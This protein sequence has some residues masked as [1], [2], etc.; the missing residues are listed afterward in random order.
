MGIG[1]GTCQGGGVDNAPRGKGRLMV[2]I[3]P[4]PFPQLP[5]PWGFCA[6]QLSN[7]LDILDIRKWETYR[8]IPLVGGISPGSPVSSPLLSGGT[9]FSPHLIYRLRKRV[10]WRWVTYPSPAI[11]VMRCGAVV[12]HGN[13][14][15]GLGRRRGLVICGRGVA[16]HPSYLLALRGGG[17]CQRGD[18]D[19]VAAEVSRS[20]VPC[21]AA[22][23]LLVLVIEV[24]ME[25]RQNERAGETGDPRENP[26]TNGIVR[27]DS[28]LRKSG[29]TRLGIDKLF[30]LS[31]TMRLCSAVESA[32][33][34][35]QER[36]NKY[37]QG[38]WKKYPEENNVPWELPL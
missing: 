16:I 26:P 28:H 10:V 18:N 31:Q 4:P 24:S 22:L 19:L 36:Q 9:P 37:W 34:D 21:D 12:S 2:V 29:V 8:T 30:K 13:P 14:G 17:R 5:E 27:H 38:M 33:G 3:P 25:Q 35:V 23:R 20:G 1:I 7:P 32:C 11:V 15:E 6:R